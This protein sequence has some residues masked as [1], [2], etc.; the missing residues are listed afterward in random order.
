MRDPGYS[1]SFLVFMTPHD[2]IQLVTGREMGRMLFRLLSREMT[3]SELAECLGLPLSTVQSRLESLVSRGVLTYRIDADHGNR[4]RYR[5]CAALMFHNCNGSAWYY[6]SKESAIRDFKSR[7]SNHHFLLL[8]IL[9]D[10]LSEHGLDLWP[11][12]PEAGSSLSYVSMLEKDLRLDRYYH[13]LEGFMTDYLPDTVLNIYAK[14]GLDIEVV[15]ESRHFDNTTL[16]LGFLAGIMRTILPEV[17]GHNYH[18]VLHVE[19]DSDRHIRHMRLERFEGGL[20]Q[21]S[22]PNV[23][24]RDLGVRQRFKVYHTYGRP[25]LVYNEQMLEMLTML[26]EGPMA[27]RDIVSRMGCP[28]TTTYHHLGRLEEIGVLHVE[29]SRNRVY[30]L[31][32]SCVLGTTNP[33]GGRMSDTLELFTRA[34][35]RERDIPLILITYLSEILECSG[36]SIDF[37]LKECARFIAEETYSSYLHMSYSEYLA[38]ICERYGTV[39]SVEW[40]S[41]IEVTIH[42]VGGDYSHDRSMMVLR[43]ILEHARPM[44]AGSNVTLS[45]EYDS[46]KH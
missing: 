15:S 20:F 14:D 7:N 10:I 1:D 31:A 45:F 39:T 19:R 21:D 42:C 40:K 9:L 24:E 38:S 30:S 26:E 32:C 4:R 41:P 29:G 37:A 8:S 6:T 34:S 23:F 11:M 16:Y 27:S 28:A 5:N 44:F 33:R 17:T 12:I 18:Q 13:N 36:I 43:E 35:E 22:L 46:D 2:G 25:I 3:A